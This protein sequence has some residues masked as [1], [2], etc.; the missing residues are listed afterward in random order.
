MTSAAAQIDEV[1]AQI[2]RLLLNDA[3]LSL[4]KSLKNAKY[5]QYPFITE[6]N[7]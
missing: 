5:R 1:D 4:K 7:A 2:L 6:L 3:R